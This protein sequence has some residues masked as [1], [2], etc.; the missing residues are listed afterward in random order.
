MNSS[1][2]HTAISRLQQ[3][4]DEEVTALGSTVHQW[5]SHEIDALT[6][7]LAARRPLLVRGEP[8][9]GKTQL[10]HAVAH[11]IG[12]SLQSMAV[13]ARTEPQDLVYRFDAVQRLADAQ[14]AGHTLLEHRYWEPGPLWKACAWQ[15]ARKFGA[16]RDAELPQPI[17]HVVLID[18]VD[19]ADADLPNSLL[20]LLG[21]RRLEIAALGKAFDLD[22]QA[23]P[24]LVFT[25]NDERLLPSAFVRRC[26]VLNQAA[27][28]D[29]TDWLCKRGAAHF[30]VLAPLGAPQLPADLMQAAAQRLVLDRER[31]RGAGVQ[32]PGLAEYIDLLTA[33]DE[34]APGDATRQWDWLRRLNAYAYLKAGDVE[35]EP[36]LSQRRPFNKSA[37]RAGPGG[38]A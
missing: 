8:G 21:Q 6:L 14:S 24:L 25:T 4:R 34:L 23:Q 26:V 37:G 35:G 2:R 27:G 20:E 9:T 29:Y 5:S 1:A 19:K 12:W 30:G 13:N 28:A 7:A 15:E 32:A 17:G 18:E 10:A 22:P 31:A 38:P 16:W 11:E 3:L 36:E 33:L